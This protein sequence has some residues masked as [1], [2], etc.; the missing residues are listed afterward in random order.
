MS[1]IISALIIILVLA[2]CQ[3]SQAAIQQ[4]IAQTQTAAP[5]VV[6]TPTIG[7]H[8]VDILIDSEIEYFVLM[9]PEWGSCY[10]MDVTSDLGGNAHSCTMEAND[11]SQCFTPIKESALLT[12]GKTVKVTLTGHYDE[13]FATCHIS[14]DGKEVVK[15]QL[16]GAS[17]ATCQVTVP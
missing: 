3:P 12:S 5:T 9:C 15:S 13:Y 2:A 16:K 4:A 11:K 14:I 8:Q 10:I 6:P 17:T 7:T 1:K